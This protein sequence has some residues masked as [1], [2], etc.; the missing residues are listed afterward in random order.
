VL[1]RIQSELREAGADVK[2]ETPDKFHITLK[3]L[4]DTETTLLPKLAENLLIR[5]AHCEA[6]RLPMKAL[7][8]S[9]HRSAQ[10]PVDRSRPNSELKQLQESV[11]QSCSGVG[12]PATT[13]LFMHMSHSEESRKPRAR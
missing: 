9:G 1:A 2:W 5:L 4:G 13:V 6:S 8:I 7:G 10:S 11:E 12:L 3:F